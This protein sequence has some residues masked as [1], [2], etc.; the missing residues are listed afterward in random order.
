MLVL[1]K[2][3]WN[4]GQT[5]ASDLEHEEW[6]AWT[7]AAWSFPGEHAERVGYPAAFPEELPRRLLKL[8]SFPGDLVI[9]PFVGSGTTSV[10]ARALG[11]RFWGCDRNPTAVARAQARLEGSGQLRAS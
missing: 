2:G 8:L 11:R 1:H 9:D 10:V 7:L 3:D 5:D 4:L 6:L